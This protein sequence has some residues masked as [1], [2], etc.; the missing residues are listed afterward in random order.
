M[1]AWSVHYEALERL[2]TGEDIILLSVG[3]ES[4]EYTPESIVEEAV[5]SLRKGRH[6]YT[7][8]EGIMTLRREIARRHQEL[9]GQKTDARN[10]AVFAGAQNALYAV[11]Q[12]LLEHG[13]EVILVEPY[14]TTYPATV[15]CGGASIKA[16]PTRAAN[17]FQ[18]VPEEIIEAMT[19]RTRAVLINSPNNPVGTVYAMDQ[20]KPLVEACAER[21]VWLIHDAVYQELLLPGDRASPAGVSG[22]DKVCITVSSLSKSHR[23]T[24]WRVG[25]A[26]GPEAL[27][28]NLYNL[29]MCM[30][31]GLPA[32][33]M[34]AAVAALRA[35]NATADTVR[36]TMNRRRAVV[37]R[38]LADA[39][40]IRVFSTQG[41]MY[42]LLDIG[43][44]GVSSQHFARTMLD[45]H[46]VSLL[47]CDGFGAT[48]RSFIRISLC[49]PDHRLQQACERLLRYCAELAD[50]VA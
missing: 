39:S 19:P 5:S 7:P 46:G 15:S 2:G 22:A 38:C 4:D 8:V 10:C 3:Q 26:V 31:Y 36:E 9:T 13:D 35:G 43:E 16:V 11:S 49:A 24:G 25:W 44:L 27:I 37:E 41:S 40:R 34:D 45:R 6:H 32:F 33:T 18:L 28:A 50:G 48:C 17:G 12:C 1:E 23:M 47:P 14:Y 20:L 21:D 29:S 30:I 42:V